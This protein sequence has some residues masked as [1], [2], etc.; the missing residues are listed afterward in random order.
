MSHFCSD[1]VANTANNVSPQYPKQINLA[2][3]QATVG[4]LATKYG[5]DNV[6]W[7]QANVTDEAQL[8][9]AFQTVA[10]HFGAGGIHLVFNNA[11]INNV[12]Q[13]G[14]KNWQG[15]IG[16]NLGGVAHG[17]QLGMQHI[18]SLPGE[19]DG[20]VKGAI[21]NTASITGLVPEKSIPVY[22]ATKWGVVGLT[23]ALQHLRSEG[24]VVGCGEHFFSRSSMMH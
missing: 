18:R 5:S 16:V 23:R 15:Q 7:I 21:I 1:P 17:T 6:I 22:S 4:E 3:G 11:G 8:E 13:E 24:I 20:G 14:F 2:L 9:R 12:L 10:S 19:R